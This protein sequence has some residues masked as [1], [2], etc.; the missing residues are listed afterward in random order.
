MARRTIRGSIIHGL[1]LLRPEGCSHPMSRALYSRLGALYSWLQGSLTFGRGARAY[2]RLK[3]LCSRSPSIAVEDRVRPTAIEDDSL[4]TRG[5]G[6][7]SGP[8][9]ALQRR[10]DLAPGV[11]HTLPRQFDW[12]LA[13]SVERVAYL[14]RSAGETGEA[15][16]RPHRSSRALV[17]ILTDHG[18]DPIVGRGRGVAPLRGFWR[19]VSP[20]FSDVEQ[21]AVSE[22]GFRTSAPDLGMSRENV[23]RRTAA[24]E[25]EDRSR[26]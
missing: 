23:H 5:A 16:P 9:R 22:Q 21:P 11:D 6:V 15:L 3:A 20:A 18:V 17:G 1:V 25:R 13:E 24:S 12:S 19:H 14:T 8:C 26:G 7:G 4:L 10:T 2:L